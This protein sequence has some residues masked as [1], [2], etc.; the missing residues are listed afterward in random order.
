MTFLKTLV[1]LFASS[2]NEEKWKNWKA[3][4]K[5]NPENLIYFSIHASFFPD[6]VIEI[7][8]F[9]EQSLTNRKD[10]NDQLQ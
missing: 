8:P 6:D 10:C 4:P 9:I 5:L 3:K 2:A 1:E 7:N